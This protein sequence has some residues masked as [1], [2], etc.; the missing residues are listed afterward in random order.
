MDGKPFNR[1]WP[2]RLLRSDA[3]DAFREWVSIAKPHGASAY[4]GS[5]QRFWSEIKRV[6]PR[7]LTVV[8]DSNGDRGIE[9]SLDDLRAGFQRY[10]RGESN[11]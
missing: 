5:E 8:K 6:I 10:M 2:T 3:L 4:T 7:L 11:E 1:K 9:I